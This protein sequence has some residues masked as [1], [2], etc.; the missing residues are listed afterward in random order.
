MTIRNFAGVVCALALAF[1]VANAHHVEECPDPNGTP[2]SCDSDGD[3]N[4]D[5]ADNCTLVQNELQRDTDGDGMGNMCDPD[6][7]NDNQINFAD[8]Q[9]MKDNFFQPGDTLTDLNGD[10]QTNFADLNMMSDM[11][12][13]QPGPGTELPICECYF[14]GDCQFGSFCNYGPGSYTVEDSC[15]WRGE[16]PSGTPGFGCSF[17]VDA[18]TGAWPPGVCDGLCDR[19]DRGSHIGLEDKGLVAQTVSIWGQAMLEPSVAGGG[20]VDPELAQEASAIQFQGANIPY[21]LG[22][23]TADALAMA[24]G[25]SFHDYFCHFEGH[26]EDDNPPTVDLAGD[27]CRIQSGQITIQALAAE[28]RTPGSAAGLMKQIMAVCPD[29]Q[30]M[31]QTDC[32]AGP[33]ALKCAV[34]RIEDMAYYLRTPPIAPAADYDPMQRILGEAAR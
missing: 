15:V 23:Y 25:G 11:F 32:A 9:V 26:P 4:D 22:R 1:S 3:G 6:F 19:S 18:T 13:D 20:P 27:A 31:F 7:N 8:L 33:G 17:E 10:G 16:K 2:N 30:N 28:I 34:Q 12:F 24:A 14:S 5:N 29:W 21:Q